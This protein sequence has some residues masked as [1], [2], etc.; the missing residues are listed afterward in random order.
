MRT[1]Y[2]AQNRM[3]Y[4][5]EFLQERK[6]CDGV[7]YAKSRQRYEKLLA[8]CRNA[9]KLICDIIEEDFIAE[10]EPE[11]D[12]DFSNTPDVN[13][14]LLS[15]VAEMKSALNKFQKFTSLIDS[16]TE[17]QETSSDDSDNSNAYPE[18]EVES[19]N[20]ELKI[21]ESPHKT[22]AE[23]PHIKPKSEDKQLTTQERRN[24][25]VSIDKHIREA[26]EDIDVFKPTCLEEEQRECIYL[27][28]DWYKARFTDSKNS[29][30]RYNVLSIYTWINDIIIT[31][32]YHKERGDKDSFV[33]KFYEWI[34]RVSSGEIKY[35]VPYDVKITGDDRNSRITE[36]AVILGS[37]LISY[38]SVNVI[39]ISSSSYPKN[40]YF[41]RYHKYPDVAGLK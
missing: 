6:A 16:T 36:I 4:I 38:F 24:V 30:F 29:E 41:D 14:E 17:K 5:L 26:V 25:L 23:N 21:G 39:H 35:A 28:R 2:A 20:N 27:I 11:S 9:V 19:P 13:P 18:S 3:D 10:N 15:I 8:D 31:Y 34:E 22:R 40:V 37:E 32:G 7:L 12:F 33:R 1:I